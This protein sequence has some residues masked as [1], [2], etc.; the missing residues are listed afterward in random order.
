M[1]D[2]EEVQE[3]EE[4]TSLRDDLEAV[5]AQAEEEAGDAIKQDTEEERPQEEVSEAAPAV[6]GKEEAAGQETTIEDKGGY[7]TLTTERLTKA[8]EGWKPAAREGWSE[9]PEQVRRE[10]HRR[11]L[12]IATGLQESAESRRLSARFEKVV[13]PYAPLMQ[14]EG[15]AEPLQAVEGLLKTA[16]TLQLGSKEQKAAKVAAMIQHYG[17]DLEALDDVLAK[18]IKGE[19]QTPDPVRKAIEER[20]APLEQFYKGMQSRIAASQQQYAGAITQ[21]IDKFAPTAEFFEDVRLDMAA[22]MEAAAGNK[23]EL[24]LQEAYN[25]ACQMNPEIKQVLEKREADKALNNTQ[26]RTQ[27]KIATASAS[28]R[29]GMVGTGAPA[30]ITSSSSLKD[31]ILASIEQL[32]G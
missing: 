11:E 2:E 6:R 32:D 26:Q 22:I 20:V 28:R 15:V 4:E 19:P 31:D 23:R 16:A 14:A 3:V 30:A 10:I 17:I 25:M 1:A 9:L 18:T 12:D 7:P 13:Q 29:P 24:G 27:R 21:E 5:I 8:P